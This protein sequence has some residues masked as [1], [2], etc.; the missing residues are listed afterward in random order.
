MIASPFPGTVPHSVAG[1]H[2]SELINRA[3]NFAT[4]A[5]QRIGHLRKYSDQP[6]QV[7]L[8]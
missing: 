3:K 1:E 7:H 6:Y 4:S 2:M 5:H 8:E